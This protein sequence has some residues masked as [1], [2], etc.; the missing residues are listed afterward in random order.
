VKEI[1]EEDQI[2]KVRLITIRLLQS[3]WFS[4]VAETDDNWRVNPKLSGGG[5][6]HDLAPHQLDII[7][8]LFGN[9]LKMHGHSYNQGK[10]YQAPD[11]TNFEAFFK[12][13]ILLNGLWSFN[14][15][16]S[17]MDDQCE[18][19]GEKGK[20]SFSFFRNPILK[21]STDSG[22]K[23]IELPYPEHVQQPLIADVVQY[24]KGRIPNPSPLEEALWSMT[25]MDVAKNA[26]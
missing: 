12:D 19:F 1:I 20:I 14:V 8:W 16:E 13:D 6:F 2:G 23:E 17:V 21:L 25:M 9:P 24:F 26:L 11:I 4:L 15:A 22:S 3:P 18:I 5:L 10:R 7:C